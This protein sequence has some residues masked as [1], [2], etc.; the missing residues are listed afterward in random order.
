MNILIKLMSIVALIIAPHISVK[1]ADG[2]VVPTTTQT[3]I[4]NRGVVLPIQQ[5][6]AS[7]V[8]TEQPAVVDG[9]QLPSTS[10]INSAQ[11][12]KKGEPVKLD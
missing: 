1:H 10:N 9:K 4:E 11:P 6:G 8:R 2:E 3:P 12:A 7:R 5:G